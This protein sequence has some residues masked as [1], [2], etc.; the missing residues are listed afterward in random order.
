MGKKIKI[1][2]FRFLIEG[3]WLHNEST[4]NG[5]FTFR[6]RRSPFKPNKFNAWTSANLNDN[7]RVYIY[8]Y[9]YIYTRKINS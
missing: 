5:F 3:R 1:R 7:K 9:I 8:K 4:N 2:K 6:G